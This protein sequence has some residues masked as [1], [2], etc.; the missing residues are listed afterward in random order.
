MQ[1]SPTLRGWLNRLGWPKVTIWLFTGIL[2]V[3]W[4]SV[5]VLFPFVELIGHLISSG[6]TLSPYTSA[7][8][9]MLKP[10]GVSATYS[11]IAAGLSV[12]LAVPIAVVIAA[13]T[14]RRRAL[15]ATAMLAPLFVNLLLRIYALRY[16]V[17]TGG[18]VESVYSS[19]ISSYPI[20]ASKGLLL[21]GLVY[22]Y[23]PF[24]VIPL[25]VSLGNV[26]ESAIDAGVVVGLQ[27]R[28]LWRAVAWVPFVRGMT[29]GWIL[30]FVPAFGDY[31][32]PAVLGGRKTQMVAN[33]LY[34]TA[35]LGGDAPAAAIGVVLLWIC[36]G[37]AMII[38]WRL[39]KRRWPRR[40]KHEA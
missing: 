30:T 14:R 19:Y 31:L 16:F 39:E 11:L 35:V 12:L 1:L 13:S 3:V 25:A 26:D 22:L 17:L 2:G 28:R 15:F 33:Y 4:L 20:F 27:G 8:N 24:A 18:F 32:A 6:F 5:L 37:A 40:R 29:I 34:D 7:F 23:L 38:W 36:T 10:I 9:Q 21:I